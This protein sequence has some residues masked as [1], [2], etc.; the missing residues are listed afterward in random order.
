[1]F[2]VS[3]QLTDSLKNLL[4]ETAKQLKGALK[5]K[6]MA[7]T[8]TACRIRTELFAKGTSIGPNDFQIAAIALTHNLTLVTHNTR[9]FSRVSG[10]IIDDWE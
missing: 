2:K 10:L 4:R 8:V 1:M 9:E 7:Q 6:F 5:R 3:I